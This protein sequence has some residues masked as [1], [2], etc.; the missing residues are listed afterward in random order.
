MMELAIAAICV[1]IGGRTKHEPLWKYGRNKALA[2][3]QWGN[4]ELLGHPDE[5][6]SSRLGR[7]YGQERYIW[8]KLLRISV[9]FIAL[10]GFNDPDHC[11]NSIIDLEQQKFRSFDYE[12]WSW[13]K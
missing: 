2:I 1:F 9:D 3:D 6:I 4:A 5:T 8:V 11:R 7:A 13:I 10:H 12:I